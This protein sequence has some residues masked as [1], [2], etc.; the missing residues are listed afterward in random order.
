MVGQVPIANNVFRTRSVF[1]LFAINL[2]NVFAKMAGLDNIVMWVRD[3]NFE[4]SFC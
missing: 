1:M 2:M 3:S 4:T